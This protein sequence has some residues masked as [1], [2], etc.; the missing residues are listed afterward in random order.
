MLMTTLECMAKYGSFYRIAQAIR[1]GELYKIA[2]GVYSDN[3]RYRVVELLLKKY[4][5]A[6]VTM[7][8]AY[9]YWNYC[10]L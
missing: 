5:T 7:L 3:K 8:S 10:K 6:V 9:Y 2:H 4:P 1:S